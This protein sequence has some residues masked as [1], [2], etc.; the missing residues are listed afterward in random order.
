VS[1]R[2]HVPRRERPRSGA[3]L[4]RSCRRKSCTYMPRIAGSR[5]ARMMAST[6]LQGLGSSDERRA[7]HP[8]HTPKA[9]VSGR[10]KNDSNSRPVFEC[11]RNERAHPAPAPRTNLS[12]C[13]QVRSAIALDAPENPRPHR[14]H[15]FR[16]WKVVFFLSSA[17]VG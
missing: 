16:L 13:L 8:L 17:L 15:P 9:K 14:R 4:R 10:L 11:R 12:I 5:F 2:R 1:R 3:K 6:R 7:W